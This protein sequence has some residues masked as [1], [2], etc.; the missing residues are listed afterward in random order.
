M[1]IKKLT[2][3]LLSF[4]LLSSPAFAASKDI[5]YGSEST[6]KSLDPHDTSDTYSGAIEKTMLQGLM[7]FDKDLKVIP[8]LAESYT[9][10]DAAT[11][12]TFKLR[13]FSEGENIFFAGL[14]MTVDHHTP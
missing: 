11:E 4:L 5:I 10:N 2:L 3:I 6:A 13:N 14:Q 7:G 12:F 8:L 1:T 9:F